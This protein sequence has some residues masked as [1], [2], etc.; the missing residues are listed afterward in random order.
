MWALN[1]K[2]LL[3]GA[4][5]LIAG[6]LF[7][8][9]LLLHLDYGVYMFTLC[10]MDTLAGGAL[11]AILEPELA[12]KLRLRKP[13]LL[14]GIFSVLLALVLYA[15]LSG[16]ANYWVQVFKYSYFCL[17]FV[18][19]LFLVITAPPEDFL[20]KILESRTLRFIGK[21]SYGIYILHPFIMTGLLFSMGGGRP[22]LLSAFRIDHIVWTAGVE[23]LLTLGALILISWLVWLCYE[24]PFLKLKRYFEYK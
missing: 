2:Q 17:F 15:G 12:G 6:A 8:R 19:V 14:G 20:R 22:G 5:G 10:R 18:G 11:M 13:I 1:R 4:I 21:I 16:A 23:P 24:Q 7:F 9:M 3:Y